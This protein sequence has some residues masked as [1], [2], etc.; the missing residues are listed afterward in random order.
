MAEETKGAMVSHNLE[1]V[2]RIIGSKADLYEA[3]VRNGWYLPKYKC[4]II[5]EAYITAV[6]TGKL[7]SPK[8]EE[9]RLVPC[10]KPPEKEVL[11]RDFNTLMTA[12]KRASG[13][14]DAH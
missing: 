10:P 9:I 13:F 1:D 8:Y 11:L 3:A 4:N 12:H 14:D 2:K 5:T 6:I 7:Y